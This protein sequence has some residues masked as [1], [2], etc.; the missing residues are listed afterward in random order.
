MRRFPR[1]VGLVLRRARVVIGVSQLLADAA[2]RCGVRDA[3]FVPNGVALPDRLSEEADPAEVLFVGRL[4]PEKGI[5]EL[6]EATA[7]MNLVAAGD[8]PL[9]ELLPS[10]LGFVPHD[11]LEKLYARAAVLVCSSYGEGLPIC[12]I[13]AMSYGLPVVA[14]TV[15]GIPSLV[16]DGRTGFLVPP[17]DARALRDR[18]EWLLS[19]S[20]MRHRMGRAGREKIAAMCSWDRV[21][22][23]TVDTYVTAVGDGLE[24]RRSRVPFVGRD[25]RARAEERAAA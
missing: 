11:E 21:T 18:L 1:L 20:A 13:E 2:A 5:R 10:A 6:A 14:T 8:G 19:D 25:R 24:R 22:Q 17:G 4:A 9:R 7:G 3:R 23:L 12:V 15:G 16:D